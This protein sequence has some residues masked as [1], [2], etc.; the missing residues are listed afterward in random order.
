MMTV[1]LMKEQQ[2]PLPVEDDECD[3]SYYSRPTTKTS[4][5]STSLYRVASS[6]EISDFLQQQ[7]L[8]LT[9]ENRLDNAD[10]DCS[11]DGSLLSS[12]TRTTVSLLPQTPITKS[13][14]KPV[15]T[16]S[17]TYTK[18]ITPYLSQSCFASITSTPIKL[19]SDHDLT[20]LSWL[21]NFKVDQQIETAIKD[22]VHSG[23]GDQQQDE[24]NKTTK[25]L[26]KLIS[27]LKQVDPRQMELASTTTNQD[28][29]L[30]SYGVII[31]LS[32]KAQTKSWCLSI[33]DLY[34][35]IQEKY[36]YYKTAKRGW[37]NAIRDT[38]VQIPCFKKVK[39]EAIPHHH[40]SVW[41][42]DPYYRPLLSKAFGSIPVQKTVTDIPKQKDAL[43]NATPNQ[44]DSTTTNES[45]CPSSILSDF[46][47]KATVKSK[48]LFPRLFE[49]FCEQTDT[50][51]H[52][53]DSNHVRST[54]T[55]SLPIKP[56]SSSAKRRAPENSDN[57]SNK[58]NLIQ[59]SSKRTRDS[60]LWRSK[61]ILQRYSNSQ[62]RDSKRQRQNSI[63]N[64]DRKKSGEEHA[65][66]R[67]SIV[68]KSSTPI[69]YTPFPSTDHTY[70]ICI[71]K[72]RTQ[73][74]IRSTGSS[75]GSIEYNDCS[76]HLAKAKILTTQNSNLV[77]EDDEA[78]SS[79]SP[80]KKIEKTTPKSPPPVSRRQP[81]A[82][83][84]KSK[85]SE[86]KRKLRPVQS[87]IVEPSPTNRKQKMST[88]T[89]RQSSSRPSQTAKI[90]RPN[91][92]RVTPLVSNRINRRVIEEDLEL[93]RQSTNQ[94]AQP[95]DLT[96]IRKRPLL[97]SHDLL[98]LSEVASNALEELEQQKQ[99]QQHENS[100]ILNIEEIGNDDGVL[101][102]SMTSA[103][104]EH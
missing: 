73:K 15:T 64:D 8:R 25:L 44:H 11:M 12:F 74:R 18:P 42:I 22:E 75:V 76:K 2:P 97:S 63:D 98:K 16:A 78:D 81:I 57:N 23:T 33:K 34:E 26:A 39:R 4:T 55:A 102:L 46:A 100:E 17:A 101:D 77:E 71:I 54:D 36:P 9:N 45:K 38:L 93:L 53:A 59:S 30:L 5:L 35:D 61:K 20:E 96:V 68:V 83:R 72:R 66:R 70:G 40:R 104:S 56:S 31:F 7:S 48:E 51:D 92:P 6:D 13:T 47:P 14:L 67:T 65:R 103:H 19:K 50:N 37:K 69:I 52:E 80:R 86:L 89:R 94:V 88:K 43:S 28:K 41:T 1:N 21:N 85:Q 27:E 91:R 24:E 99:Q 60:K 10:S 82:T 90:R 3:S 84:S 58:S 87:L 95:L 32:L 49:K 29:P 79:R 62:I